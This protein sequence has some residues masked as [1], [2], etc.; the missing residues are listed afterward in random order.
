LF[1]A[2]AACLSGENLVAAD[3]SPVTVKAPEEPVWTGERVRFVIEL[4]TQGSFTGTAGFDLPELPGT[5]V[6]RVGSPV[7]GSEQVD[8]ED[9]FV[10]THQFA[11]FSQQNGRLEIPSFEVRFQRREGFTGPV[12]DV[13]AQTEPFGIEIRRPP[14]S[15]DIPFLITA[16]TYEVEETWDP[17]PAPQAKVGDIFRRTV[18]QRADNMT[19]MALIPAST[20]APEAVRVY[21]PK[22]ETSDNT[23]RGAF[24]GERRETLTYRLLQPGVVELPA[25]TYAWWN[26]K[27]ETLQSKQL[28]AVTLEVAAVPG[29]ATEEA[30]PTR[31]AWP[32]LLAGLGLVIAGFWWRRS[33]GALLKRVWRFLNP[34]ERGVRRR[35]LGAC[36]RSDVDAALAAWQEW[37]RINER[38]FRATPAF[39]EALVELQRQRYGAGD[40]GPWNGEAFAIAFGESRAQSAGAPSPREASALPEL[41]RTRFGA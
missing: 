27:T 19:G 8:G 25:L 23:Q 1:L 41:N 28:P 4:R 14:G 29:A 20:R 33:I 7:V 6:M 17:V 24:E 13:S 38:P 37:T 32:W 31:R 30:K 3:V 26:P 22:A 18:V 39:E 10:Q 36:R 12:E 40:A 5:L 16:E 35:L 21:P 15:E 2:T 34:P 9:W 11:L